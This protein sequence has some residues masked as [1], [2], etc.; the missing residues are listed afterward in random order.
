MPNEVLRRSHYLT[1]LSRLQPGLAHVA[2][3]DLGNVALQLHLL[4]ELIDR[5]EGADEGALARLKSPLD[6]ARAGLDRLEVTVLRSLGAMAP[7]AIEPE[8]D[9]HALLAALGPLLA[10]AA[11]ERR[12]ECV[13]TPGDAEMHVRIPHGMLR[14]SLAI[15]AV[16]VLAATPDAGRFDARLDSRDGVARFTLSGGEIAADADELAVAGSALQGMGGLLRVEPAP[17]RLVL[18]V[19]LIS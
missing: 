9:A 2:R 1:A 3:S 14:D 7:A 17:T 16:A 18:E 4:S 12:V 5:T 6:R 11:K 19:P 15:A 8:A 10:A 13:I